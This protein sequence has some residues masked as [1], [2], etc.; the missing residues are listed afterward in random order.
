MV[1]RANEPQR[2][3]LGEVTNKVTQLVNL[4]GSEIDDVRARISLDKAS[5]NLF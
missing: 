1:V 3:F 2:I 5:V 4:L